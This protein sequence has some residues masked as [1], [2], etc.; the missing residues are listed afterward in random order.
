MLLDFGLARL[1]RAGT[2]AASAGGT[3][4]FMAPEQLTQRRVDERSD[5]FS[6]GL[7]LFTLLT[8]WRRQRASEIVPPLDR[9]SDAPLRAIL[10]RALASIRPRA[11]RAPGTSRPPSAS[12]PPRVGAGWS[13]PRPRPRTIGARRW[14]PSAASPSRPSHRR[15]AACDHSRSAIAIGSSVG[16]ARSPT[17]S[18]TSS[19]SRP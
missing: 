1:A 8:G 12:S 7:V 9:I 3:P 13:F 17:C 6:A 4:Q 16:I 18:I 2:T 19:S 10:A 14:P 11:I 15:S 5:L